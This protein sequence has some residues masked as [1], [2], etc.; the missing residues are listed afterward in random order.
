MR[1]WT[2]TIP[3]RY[4]ALGNDV[5]DSGD[6]AIAKAQVEAHEKMLEEL[7]LGEDA[8]QAEIDEAKAKKAKEDKYEAD[9][10]LVEDYET[11]F[12]KPEDEPPDEDPTPEETAAYNKAKA[13]I[14]AYEAPIETPPGENSPPVSDTTGPM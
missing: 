6:Y 5:T 9:K 1:P 7:G 8:T 3:R 12:G 4:D 10:Q 11:D 2:N 14:A 13:D